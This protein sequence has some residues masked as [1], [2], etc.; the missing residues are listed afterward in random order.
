MSVPDNE[1]SSRSSSNRVPESASDKHEASTVADISVC[2]WYQTRNAV[3]VVTVG[4][5]LRIILWSW[6]E[7]ET[8]HRG[9]PSP[10]GGPSTPSSFLSQEVLL[11]F[12]TPAT[13]YESLRE[14]DAL[15]K[16]QQSSS[17]HAA[18]PV[19][20]R[21]RRPSPYVNDVVRTPPLILFLLNSFGCLSS[22]SRQFVFLLIVEALTALLL[23]ATVLRL[24]REKQRRI[25]LSV[26]VE[27]N[28]NTCGKEKSGECPRDE[29]TESTWIVERTAELAQPWMVVALYHLNPLNVSV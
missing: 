3:L 25:D 13:S 26:R 4:V 7:S 16:L 28:S 17:S 8:Q 10:N 12:Y 24:Q 19:D 6:L 2:K 18:F 21:Y 22:R 15:I 20:S 23:G 5:I 14:A 9:S 1:A 27:R 11:A 29:S